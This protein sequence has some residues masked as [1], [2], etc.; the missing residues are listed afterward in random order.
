M[1]LG[2]WV[3]GGGLCWDGVDDGE[4]VRA[5]QTA[6]DGGVTLIDTAPAYGWGH[7]EK[8]VGKA[9]KGRRDEVVIATKCGIWWEDDRGTAFANFDGKDTNISLR[10]ETIRIEVENSLRRLDVDCI[11]L[12]QVH[13]PA[14]EP[15]DTPID[16]TMAC[17]M[18]LKAAGK[19]RAI[20]ACN[21]SIEQLDAYRANGDL[22]SDQFRY[23]MLYR[24][25]EGDVLPYCG[26][27]N[28]ATLTYMSL[29]QGML[30]GKVGMDRVF[31]EDEFRSDAAWNPW[32]ALDNR[33][34]VLDMLASWPDLTDKYDCSLA[35]LAIAWT[36]A[37]AGVTHVLCGTRTVAQAK[38][39]AAAGALVLEDGDLARIRAD[40]VAL[41]DPA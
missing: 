36:A 27:H 9:I 4:S 12:L 16:V 39:N 32:Y 11:D 19:I 13:W 14:P 24:E 35:Q 20:G 28:L 34:R 3:T 8:V 1:G 29:E 18:E 26:E 15:E 33:K 10:P 6:L 38:Q 22:V 21:L 5:I 23:G 40:V 17:L 37:Q 25:P 30:T 31:K 2:T 41:G 7:S